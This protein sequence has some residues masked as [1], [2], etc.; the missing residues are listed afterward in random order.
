MLTTP[1][2]RSEGAQDIPFSPFNANFALQAFQPLMTGM[3][4][5]NGKACTSWLE[6]HRQWTGFVTQRLQEDVALVHRLANCT[7]PMDVYGVYSDF[8]QKALADY[9]REFAEMTKL[10]QTWFAEASRCAQQAK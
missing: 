2:A 4:A 10:G 3:A 8:F 6:I 5:S 9:Q 7:N 1:N